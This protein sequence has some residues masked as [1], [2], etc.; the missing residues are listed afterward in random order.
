MSDDETK[1]LREL[2]EGEFKLAP[3][4]LVED[5][6]EILEQPKMAWWL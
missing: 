5:G 6:K 1:F 4:W 2:T 3:R